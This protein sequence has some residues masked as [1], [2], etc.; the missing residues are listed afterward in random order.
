MSACDLEKDW[1]V[2]TVAV[3]KFLEAQSVVDLATLA[4]YLGVGN[5]Y[6]QHVQSPQGMFQNLTLRVNYALRAW[7]AMQTNQDDL[8]S[9]IISII[10]EKDWKR[11]CTSLLTGLEGKTQQSEISRTNQGKTQQPSSSRTNH[12][13]GGIILNGNSTIKQGGV[14]AE[15]ITGEMNGGNVVIHKGN[16]SSDKGIMFFTVGVL[17]VLIALIVQYGFKNIAKAD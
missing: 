14:Q 7:R 5:A 16:S 13:T 8:R 15:I 11:Q 10:Q 6:Q 12:Q 9:K 3:E 4:N 17:F 2:I 1:E